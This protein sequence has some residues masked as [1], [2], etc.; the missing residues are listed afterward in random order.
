[1][2]A[3]RL[4]GFDRPTIH[5]TQTHF[6]DARKKESPHAVRIIIEGSNPLVDERIFDRKARKAIWTKKRRVRYRATRRSLR[7]R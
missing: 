4:R 3:H 6:R 5:F 7:R 2:P 1:L